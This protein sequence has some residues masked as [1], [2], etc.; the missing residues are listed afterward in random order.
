MFLKSKFKGNR[1]VTQRLLDLPRK[2][3][4]KKSAPDNPAQKIKAKK[5]FQ[6]IV[7]YI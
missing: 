5:L 4:K 6:L 2:N 7:V 3:I 1:N